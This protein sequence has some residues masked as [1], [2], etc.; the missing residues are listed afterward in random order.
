[1]ILT[2]PKSVIFTKHMS[3]MCFLEIVDLARDPKSAN[4]DGFRA[5]SGE[6]R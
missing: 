1:M 4:F 2:P 6:I 5:K 3:K